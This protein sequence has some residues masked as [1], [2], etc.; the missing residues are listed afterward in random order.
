MVFTFINISN[1][2]VSR[3]SVILGLN[4]ITRSLEK[5]NV[6]C[7]LMDANIEPQILLRHIIVMAQNKQVPILLLPDLKSITLSIIGFA[8]AAYALKVQYFNYLDNIIQMLRY[9]YNLILEYCN[10]IS[11]SS[12]PSIIYKNI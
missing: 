11:Q 12:F 5:N 4:A 10:G 2:Y 9:L 7:V 8:S 1:V 3:N 6:C